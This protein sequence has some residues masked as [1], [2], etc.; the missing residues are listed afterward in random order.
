VKVLILGAS[1]MIG[2]RMWA[3][4]GKVHET[5]GVIRRPELGPLANIEGI[6]SQ[7]SFCNVDVK[8]ISKIDSIIGEVKPDVVLNCVGVIKQLKESKNPIV[9]IQSNS[10]FPHL[11]AEICEKH[12][13]RM[14]QFSTDCVYDGRDGF[15]DEND[16]A[17]ATDLYGKTKSLGEVTQYKNVVTIRTSCV[18]REVF[19]ANGLLEW[20]VSQ[21][22]GKVG[23]FTKAIFSGFP[24]K[25]LAKILLEKIV[26]NE[27]LNGLYHI[28]SQ[29]IN[30]YELLKAFKD[31]LG[32]DIEIE[33]NNEFEVDRSLNSDHFNKTVG[34]E[35]LP[36][37][38]LVEDI[39]V[40]NDFYNGL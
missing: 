1:G 10:L 5:Y 20:F 21:N 17:N 8:D 23:G 11:L 18:G 38:E 34:F 7:Q 39:M 30:K 6:N 2:H 15:Y 31:T 25:T 32:L 35:Y 22:G 13:S 3:E 37:T 16:S 26:P 36:W 9:T 29:K 27:E 12:N 28:A 33:V 19:E 4:F 24:A 14:I 40:D